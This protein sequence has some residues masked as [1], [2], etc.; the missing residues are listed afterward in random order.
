MR[1][2]TKEIIDHFQSQWASIDGEKQEKYF[3]KQVS[4]V[5]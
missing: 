5:V 1:S 3:K 4:T 2:F